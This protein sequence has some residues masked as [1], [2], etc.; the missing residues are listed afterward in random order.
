MQT[1]ATAFEQMNNT[2]AAIEAQKKIRRDDDLISTQ[3]STADFVK[4]LRS[5]L[6]LY[7]TVS[8]F[9]A[10]LIVSLVGIWP[11]YYQIKEAQQ[12]LLVSAAETRSMTVEQFLSRARD[13][14]SQVTSR[15]KVRLKLEAYNAGEVT[16]EELV[17][18]SSK[19][20]N[21][22]LVQTNELV[23]ITRL[24]AKEQLA[25]MLG[26]KIPDEYWFVPKDTVKQPVINGP[27]KI[28]GI[29]YLVISAPILSREG[30]RAGTDI[31]LY[32]VVGLKS[33]VS[34]YTG[35]SNSGQMILGQRTDDGV[36]ILFPMRNAT[37]EQ[38]MEIYDTS[39]Y[40]YEGIS[41]AVE[42]QKGITLVKAR[43]FQELAVAYT[44]VS[45]S[46]WGLIIQIASDELFADINSEILGIAAALVVLLGMGVSA[47]V[48]LLRPLAGKV[49]IHTDDLQSE[50]RVKTAALQIE[51]DARKRI[52]KSLSEKSQR[53]E[54]VNAEL[55]QFAYIASHD[56]KAPLRA[57]ANL[58]NWIAEDL[59][60][61]LDE[62]TSKQMDLLMSR[63]HRMENLIEGILNY[64]RAGRESVPSEL[65]NTTE[66]VREIA[67][68]LAVKPGFEIKIQ[69]NMP[70]FET[71]KVRLEQV[72]ANLISNSLK[73]HNKETGKIEVGCKE[74]EDQYEFF[75]RDDGPGIAA[76]Y[77]EKVFKIFQ[78]LQARD[79]IESTGIG[80]TVVKKIV[81]EEGGNISIE[82]E[83]GKG[84]TFRFTWP[85][86]T[87]K[88][89]E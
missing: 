50:I 57:I 23:G 48:F 36:R 12:R 75:V 30:V 46:N 20:L 29:D 73:Y 22:A 37:N 59:G 51:L 31:I 10:G 4:Q 32:D 79:T 88:N 64:S 6:L 89:E 3:N 43:N 67:E 26:S 45:D 19:P 76:E 39:S 56:L 40:L 11:L 68:G 61:R 87:R 85:K 5:S 70:V 69:E 44:P 52:Q 55:D 8:I 42:K 33:I 53:L 28:N 65:V 47:M 17:Q 78:T 25:L 27:F 83:E 35:L 71:A 60:D 81:Q 21:D 62:G 41:K 82:S 7:A 63:V 74:L 86:V 84:A 1:S 72:F 66:F 14:A 49:L 13:V 77:H 38:G 2:S 54:K 58:A 18:F 16:R 9:T 24:D 80:L 34:D 15:T